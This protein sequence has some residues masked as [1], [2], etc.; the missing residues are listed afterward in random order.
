MDIEFVS[1]E[2]SC[3]YGYMLANEKFH[4]LMLNEQDIAFFDCMKKMQ[5]NI[6]EGN[7]NNIDELNNFIKQ[8]LSD[9]P[10]KVEQFSRDSIKEMQEYSSFYQQNAETIKQ[11]K[12]A[13]EERQTDAQKGYSQDLSKLYDFFDVDKNFKC[14][15]FLVPVPQKAADG[16]AL[17]NNSF[18]VCFETLKKNDEKY[19]GNSLLPERKVS[20][21]LHESTHVLFH[22]S[23]IKQDLKNKQGTGA[24]KLLS[25]LD[26]YFNEH[27]DSK[28]RSAILAV[29]EAL[30]ACSSMVVNTKY[31]PNE[32]FDIFYYDFEGANE[33]AK[34]FYPVYQEYMKQGKKLDDNFWMRA[35]TSFEL[36]QRILS[37]RGKLPHSTTV[38]KPKTL[39][40]LRGIG[41]KEVL[42]PVEKTSLDMRE[43][44]QKAMQNQK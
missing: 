14:Y 6:C 18:M 29:D 20:T 4:T 16:F 31:K 38:L 2:M 33:L 21:P 3:I 25:V 5:H 23:K 34:S 24:N 35:A 10:E 36:H 8:Q 17:T 32:K 30:A 27:P 41:N 7:I 43:I 40:K 42:G 37:I 26:K 28:G 22:N 39:D 19:I 13:A 9:R 44:Q 11:Y 15:G 12:Q 1:T